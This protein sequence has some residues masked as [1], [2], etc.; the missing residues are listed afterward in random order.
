[1]TQIPTHDMT[2]ED[3]HDKTWKR[4]LRFSTDHKVIGVQYLVTA[5]TFFLVG[6]LLAM[7]V[8]AELLTPPLD[9]VSRTAYN[10]L[11]TLHGAIAK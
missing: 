8:R 9:I 5:F 1:M 3:I 10:E 4:Y 6:G 7:I 11:F 2:P